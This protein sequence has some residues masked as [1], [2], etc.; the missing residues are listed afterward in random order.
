MSEQKL[1]Q[2]FS[3]YDADKSGYIEY[4]EFKKIWVSV[5]DVKKELTERGIKVPKLATREKL[6]K[7]LQDILDDEEDRWIFTPIRAKSL[8]RDSKRGAMRRSHCMLWLLADTAG[9]NIDAS[10]FT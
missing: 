1:E 4:P 2:L 7:I 5:A 10:K 8:R 3:K 6:S 9:H